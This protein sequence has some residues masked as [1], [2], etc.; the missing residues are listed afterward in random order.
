MSVHAKK[1]G[2]EVMMGWNHPCDTVYVGWAASWKGQELH[3]EPAPG[4]KEEN[5][6]LAPKWLLFWSQHGCP[7]GQV[8]YIALSRTS[9][10]HR[11]SRHALFQK[12]VASTYRMQDNILRLV[13]W[14]EVDVDKT[15][16]TC[17]FIKRTASLCSCPVGICQVCLFREDGQRAGSFICGNL[18]SYDDQ[19]VW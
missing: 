19:W 11:L 3:E 8:W 15:T 9:V 12:R 14:L 16:R 10:G 6:D 7:Y 18:V 5:E 1:S 13:Y 17:C 2:G 4:P